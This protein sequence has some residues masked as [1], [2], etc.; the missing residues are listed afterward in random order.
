MFFS[1]KMV[2]SDTKSAM[3]ILQ[4]RKKRIVQKPFAAMM[5]EYTSMIQS[6]NSQR[7]ERGMEQNAAFLSVFRAALHRLPLAEIADELWPAVLEIADRQHVY[8][9]ISEKLANLAAFCDSVH[10]E[11]VLQ[12]SVRYT[13]VQENREAQFLHLYMAMRKAGLHPLVM[14]GMVCRVAY[15]DLG[16]LRPSGDEDLLIS[17]AEFWDAWQVL[18]SNGY[19]PMSKAKPTNA[20]LV[21]HVA[22]QHESGYAIEL[23]VRPIGTEPTHLQRMDQ[24]FD[25]AHKRAVTMAYKGVELHT[26]CPTD[27]YLLLIFH[28]AKH[29]YSLGFGIRPLADMAVYY[30]QY[31]R[32]IQLADVYAALDACRLMPLYRDLV[33][34]AN[35]QLGFDLPVPGDAVCPDRLLAHMLDGGV[36]G[37]RDTTTLVS[38]LMVNSKVSSGHRFGKSVWRVVF[39]SRERV[40][41]AHPEYAGKPL[42]WLLHYP[43]RWM[44]GIRTML[45]PRRTTPIRSLRSAHERLEL[46]HLYGME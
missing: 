9:L 44:K 35:G 7:Q 41:R 10:Y 26:L 19:Q 30:T 46:L 17:A 29:F 3:I 31:A 42:K 6:E 1:R 39:P 28:M 22:F 24:Y 32:E 40:L 37:A 11:R 4:S 8:A 23:H 36:L 25:D 45:G 12:K 21:H 15:G 13:L 18:E 27:H 14:K 5:N 43:Q 2:L 33:D 20:E 38:S 16:R 34:I